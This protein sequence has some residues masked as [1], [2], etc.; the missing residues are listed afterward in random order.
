MNENKIVTATLAVGIGNPKKSDTDT[1]SLTLAVPANQQWWQW[2]QALEE[3]AEPILR[4][5]GA[6]N[7]VLYYRLDGSTTPLTVWQRIADFWSKLTWR[8]TPYTGH[9]FI[10]VWDLPQ[11][12]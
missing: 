8:G 12:A 4:S 1:Q 6:Q 5:K 3:V 2:V 7:G 9:R 10:P 11:R